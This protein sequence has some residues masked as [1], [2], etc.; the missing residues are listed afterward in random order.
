METIRIVIQITLIIAA[1]FNMLSPLMFKEQNFKVQNS[2]G[3]FVVIML[4]LGNM[5]D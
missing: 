2:L 4:T 3:W 1:M 5:I